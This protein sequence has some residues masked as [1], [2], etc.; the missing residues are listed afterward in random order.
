MNHDEFLLHCACVE[1][2]DYQYPHLSQLLFHPANEGKRT[3]KEGNK[4]KK[5]G[6]RKG[7]PDLFLSVPKIIDTEMIK[8]IFHGIYFEIKTGRRRQTKEQKSF[9]EKVTKQEY[10]YHIVD[11]FELFQFLV[12]IYL[13]GIKIV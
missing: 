5:M 2:F 4:L 8:K 12:N 1:W 13:L 10:A 7:V 6:M 11:S 3:P 9:E